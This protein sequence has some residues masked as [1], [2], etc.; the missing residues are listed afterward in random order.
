MEAKLEN[1]I[2]L[3]GDDSG[4]DDSKGANLEGM[5]PEFVAMMRRDAGEPEGGESGLDAALD[6]EEKAKNEES[7][8]KAAEVV[9]RESELVTTAKSQKKMHQALTAALIGPALPTTE[10]QIQSPRHSELKHKKKKKSKKK[11]AQPLVSSDVWVD[12]SSVAAPSKPGLKEWGQAKATPKDGRRPTFDYD[13]A[14]EADEPVEDNS[15]FESLNADDIL[16][17]FKEEWS[18][19]QNIDSDA[20]GGRFSALVASVFE[21]TG[22]N[23]NRFVGLLGNASGKSEK[24]VDNL[25]W[26]AQDTSKPWFSATK[27]QEAAA[28]VVGSEDLTEHKR[29]HPRDSFVMALQTCSRNSTPQ[30]N[31]DAA[32][33]TLLKRVSF[34][35]QHQQLQP[36]GVGEDG[37]KQDQ[38]EVSPL[39]PTP[40]LQP[41]TLSSPLSL[42]SRDY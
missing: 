25:L 17:V 26:E 1:C 23:M 35:L 34:L 14:V 2:W 20:V 39:T 40:P 37:S 30:S 32:E 7:T 28:T 36:N 8:R 21:L 12:T 5:A 22:R 29:L 18:H 15:T 16:D 42:P 11:A 38:P 19:C 24:E 27:A 13:E 9:K 3:G 31:P 33:Q 4:A 6:S 10:D 41:R